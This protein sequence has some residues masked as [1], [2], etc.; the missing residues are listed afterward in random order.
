M[1]KKSIVFV[2]AALLLAAVCALLSL[3]KRESGDGRKT[4]ADYKDGNLSE[5]DFICKNGNWGIEYDGK[6]KV[7]N[8]NDTD[9][10]A[11]ENLVSS[12]LRFKGNLVCPLGENAVDYGIGENSL[13]IVYT[14]KD[15]RQKTFVLGDKT[16]PGTEYYLS[17]GKNIYTVYSETGDAFK[18]EKYSAESSF[19]YG[20]DYG[21]ISKITV[22]GSP[23]LEF[24]NR[25]SKWIVKSG[26][27]SEEVSID[28]IRSGITRHFGGMYSKMTLDGNLQNDEKCGF[29]D[30]S[31]VTTVTI[32]SFGGN[33]DTL[34]LGKETDDGIYIKVNDNDKIYK[35][36]KQ[37]FEFIKLYRE[38]VY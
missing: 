13:K 20:I 23:A 37:Y 31:V 38:G 25:Q 24:V 14:E 2:I 34:Y 5:V 17:D 7:K 30:G 3:P 21:S 18:S 27:Y 1:T 26:G 29:A 36:I 16:P 9:D 8:S 11:I 4:L 33:T 10:T 6:W 19:V 22:S 32:E 15:G 28:K 35:V 12:I